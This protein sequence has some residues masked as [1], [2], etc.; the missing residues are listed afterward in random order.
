MGL[1]T[2]FEIYIRRVLKQIHPETG[3]SGSALSCLNNL[4]EI[5]V[6]K[7]MVGVDRILLATSKKTVNARDIQDA[8]RLTLPGELCKHAVSEGT[9]AVVKYNGSK[10]A[11]MPGDKPVMKSS[12][13]GLCFSVP[14]IQKL[15]MRMSVVQRKTG[16][17]AVYITAVCEYLMAEIMEL[18]G[19]IARDSKRVRITPR[20]IKLAVCNDEELKVF[21]KDTVF[22]GGVMPHIDAKVLE[23]K[24][25]KKAS[26]T[27]GTKKA[28]KPKPKPKAN[29]QKKKPAAKS[30]KKK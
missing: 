10:A 13:A 15:M 19:N 28:P 11:G 30:T 27:K 5:T 26:T 7:I 3:I 25:K 23:K 1:D 20:H 21:Y 22:A 9:K 24:G 8:V 14:R 2:N 29:S 6:Q 12:R 17:A 16:V 18:A 4:V